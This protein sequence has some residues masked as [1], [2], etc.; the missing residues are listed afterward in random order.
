MNKE[1]NLVLDVE[2]N[3]KKI[4]QWILF[5]LQHILAMLVACITVPLLTGLPIAATIISAGIGTICYIFITKLKS[6]VFLSSSFAYLAPMSSALAIGLIGQATGMNYLALI[7]GM[8]LVG[9]VYV[10][11]SIVIKFVGTNWLNKILPPVIVG[12]VIMVI[13]LS[14]AGS[15]VSNLTRASSS[16]EPYNLIALLCGLIA[17]FVTAISS[18]YGKGKMASLIPFVIGMG[19]GYI[20]AVL[21]SVFGY[22]IGKNE[23]FNIVNFTPLIEL[24]GDN[25]SF[26]SIIN[27]RIF[28]PNDPESF[29]FLRFEEI[30]KFDWISITEIIALFVP[31]SLVTICEHIGDHKNLGNIIGRDLLNDEPG[32]S[33]TLLG[34]GIATAV[35]GALCGAAN[36]TYGENVAVIGTTRIASVKVVLLAAVLSIAIGFVTPFTALLETIPSCVTGGVSL[37]LYGFIASSGV[38]MLIQEKIDFSNTKNI[39]IT[40]AILVVGIGGLSLKFGNPNSPVITITSIAVAMIIGILLNF[41]LRD[42][43]SK[44]EIEE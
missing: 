14:L 10:I 35:S 13:G 27:Y 1:K 2:E 36:T 7:I 37:V 18:F 44:K 16:G 17:L 31:V 26:A 4:S 19:S 43:K 15:A 39:F 12:P 24:F 25:F 32:M 29:I 20:A 41:V 34:D 38:K 6:P 28:V 3:P 11:V 8:V 33:R 22:V 5:S 23:Y 42:K 30:S 9:L 40:S 21:F